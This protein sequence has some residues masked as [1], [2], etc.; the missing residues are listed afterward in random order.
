MSLLRNSG[1]RAVFRI[2][3]EATWL[4]PQLYILNYPCNNLNQPKKRLFA[5]Q[6]QLLAIKSFTLL[7]PVQFWCYTGHNSCSS[8]SS[9]KVPPRNVDNISEYF[10]SRRML[11][12]QLPEIAHNFLILWTLPALDQAHRTP[13][14]PTEG[15]EVL[16]D[17]T[18][19]KGLWTMP[20]VHFAFVHLL[21]AQPS[22][23]CSQNLGARFWPSSSWTGGSQCFGLKQS[24]ERI[25]Q[26]G[27][28][29]TSTNNRSYKHQLYSISWLS[30]LL[31]YFSFF[32]FSIQCSIY[33]KVTKQADKQPPRVTSK[34]SWK[35][36]DT[37][38]RQGLRKL[39][40]CSCSASRRFLCIRHT[41]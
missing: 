7:A 8:A 9:A 36:L 1:N 24:L 14:L 11:E 25:S 31:Q 39:L 26:Y 20:R 28:H 12:K 17:S 18:L 34:F 5:I 10:F 22:S 16:A 40:L 13:P 35:E 33:F 38:I 29:I 15:A 30:S 37:S 21:A 19:Y 32:F 2:E 4:K 3:F 6:K 27:A 41:L 23:S